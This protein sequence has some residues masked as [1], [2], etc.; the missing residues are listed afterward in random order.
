MC[1]SPERFR[2]HLRV[3]RDFSPR[4]LLDL[5]SLQ[6]RG[7][8]GRSGSVA[9]TFDDGYTD[10]L[11]HALPLLEESGVPATFFIV[12]RQSSIGREYWWDELETL[13]RK[14]ESIP[15]RVEVPE[16]GSID[17]EDPNSPRSPP[18]PGLSPQRSSLYFRLWAILRPLSSE[19]QY[20]AIDGLSRQW[21]VPI[22]LREE[23]RVMNPEELASLAAAPGIS[24][25]SHTATHAYLPSVEAAR[26]VS[27]IAG[28]KAD[29]ENALGRPVTAFSYPFGMSDGPSRAVV[30]ESGYSLAIAGAR[31]LSH[32][33]ALQL[34]RVWMK[35][36]SGME[37]RRSLERRF[38][39]HTDATSV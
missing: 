6:D 13:I 28:S 7:L 27:E 15:P 11:R 26:R 8:G 20:E 33:D 34:P 18:V 3:L 25:G 16:L 4:P 32:L 24:I 12:S 30:E 38:A 19:R 5:P 21:N 23:L 39:Q 2:E 17:S 10:N 29:L 35:N 9:I 14:A 22:R 31:P 36:W 1:V 37:L